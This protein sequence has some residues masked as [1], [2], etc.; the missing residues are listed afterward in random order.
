M[1]QLLGAL[2]LL[3]AAGVA[4][5]QQSEVRIQTKPIPPSRDTLDRLNLTLA[6]RTKLPMDGLRDGIAHVQLIPGKQFPLLLVQTFKGATVAFNAETGDMLWYVTVGR[7]YE[8]AQPAGYNSQTIFVVRREYLYALDRDTGK[9]YL[10]DF[11]EPTKVPVY[12][13]QLE[14]VPSTGLVADEGALFICFS[15]RVIRYAVPNFR[16]AFKG[17]ERPF[18]PGTAAE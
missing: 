7:P 14:S 2:T 10:F 6:W 11:E 16:V 15:D 4:C 8:P 13:Y 1:K 12:G 17:V 9:H 3:L 18:K 5:C